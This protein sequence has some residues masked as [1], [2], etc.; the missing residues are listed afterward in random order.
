MSMS[1][2]EV[3]ATPR[4]RKR[5]DGGAQ[6]SSSLVQESSQSSGFNASARCSGAVEV[7]A[8]DDEGKFVKVKNISKKVSQARW[9]VVL[10]NIA[11]YPLISNHL[12]K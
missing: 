10:Y 6:A 1:Q 2:S 7:S 12:F 4:K 3:K 5:N 11:N 9:I 8:V